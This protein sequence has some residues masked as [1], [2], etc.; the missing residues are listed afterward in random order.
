MIDNVTLVAGG[1]QC[2]QGWLPVATGNMQFAALDTLQGLE[3]GAAYRLNAPAAS[4]MHI[5]AVDCIVKTTTPPPYQGTIFFHSNRL[6]LRAT[7]IY[8]QQTPHY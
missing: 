7:R 6:A 8:R 4:A 2:I 3:N 5:L 1:N